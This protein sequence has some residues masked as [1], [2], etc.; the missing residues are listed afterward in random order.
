MIPLTTLRRRPARGPDPAIR[1]FVRV[2]ED[3]ETRAAPPPARRPRR[4]PK[5]A[6]A[7]RP[8]ARGSEPGRLP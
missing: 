6:S 3:L 7:A 8:A 2:L 4:A 5:A 1:A